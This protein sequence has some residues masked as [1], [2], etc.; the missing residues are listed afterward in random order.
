MTFYIYQYRE[1]E[2]LE[3][4]K[5]LKQLIMCHEIDTHIEIPKENKKYYLMLSVCKK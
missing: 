1:D 3:V 2:F 4:L 5:P